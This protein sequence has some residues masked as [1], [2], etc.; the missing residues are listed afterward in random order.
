MP[1]TPKQEESTR[2]IVEYVKNI[3]SRLNLLLQ[4]DAA[5]I[6]IDMGVRYIKKTSDKILQ[7]LKNL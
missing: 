2:L 5:G 3:K 4:E 7:E 1:K 6:K